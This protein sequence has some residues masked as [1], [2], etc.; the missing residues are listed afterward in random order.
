MNQYLRAGAMTAGMMAI[1][2]AVTGFFHW[3]S[4]VVTPD[5][6]PM[7][8][9]CLGITSCIFFIYMMFL[10]QIRYEDE[11]KKIAKK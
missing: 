10:A 2:V 11:V 6:V 4:R 8:V 1:V 3:L 9:I 5:M 7:I